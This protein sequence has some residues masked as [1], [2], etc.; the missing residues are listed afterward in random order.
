MK[1]N[2]FVVIG[3][4]GNQPYGSIR[5]PTLIDLF[6]CLWHAGSS[7]AV[8]KRPYCSADYKD[9]KYMMTSSNGTIFRVTGPLCG[10]FTGSS[11]RPV[12]QSSAVF[13]DLRLNKR[14]SKQS[15]RRWFETSS[16]SL[17]RHC[18]DG[19]NIRCHVCSLSCLVKVF[20]KRSHEI[21]SS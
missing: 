2:L 1:I 20:L 9:V 13:L 19:M 8:S 5:P 18:N 11:Q 4:N 17:W 6:W 3:E 7:V 16:H 14:L 21:H 10:E 15:R 12:T